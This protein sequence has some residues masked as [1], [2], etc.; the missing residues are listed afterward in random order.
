ML[1]KKKAV[2]TNPRHQGGGFFLTDSLTVPHRNLLELKETSKEEILEILKESAVFKKRLDSP[3]K[4]GMELRGKTVM[5]LFFEPSTRTR[6]SFELAAK[7]L[8]AEI[9]N[10]TPSTSSMSKGEGLKDMV[11][12]LE[13]MSPDI[14]IV[15][16][17]ASGVPGL[18]AQYTRAT[19]I[20]AGDG[21]HEHPTQG[22]LDMFTIQEKCGEIKGLRVLIVG[23]IAYSR[24]AR[25][26][27]Y[28]LTKLGA[29]ITV[30]GPATLIPP[31]LEQLGVTVAHDFNQCLPT[32]D[33]VILLRIQKERQ[34]TLNFP[35]LAEYSHF[36]SLTRERLPLM[37][38]HAIIMHPGP[39]NRGVEIDPEVADAVQ[40]GRPDSGKGPRTVILDQVTNG[41]AVRMAV[42]ARYGGSR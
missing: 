8:S 13:A 9:L 40:K 39:I 41:I 11:E 5:N 4:K 34:E 21:S 1:K 32:A 33:V 14:L 12:N 17:A 7:N 24:V 29:R 19:V 23:D 3:D 10:M 42:L 31:G 25:S 27:I 36:Y 18:M 16:H 35:S 37:K 6:V 30:V 22:L 20:N 26:N 38:P 28:G 15:R 2:L